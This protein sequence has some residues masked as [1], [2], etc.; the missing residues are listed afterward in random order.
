MN[1]LTVSLSAPIL[2]FP[3]CMLPLPPCR[4]R[5]SQLRHMP[6]IHPY[7]QLHSTLHGIQLELA[8]GLAECPPV[9]ALRRPH[10][11]ALCPVRA[12]HLNYLLTGRPPLLALLPPLSLLASRCLIIAVATAVRLPGRLL[13][14]L[15]Q[16]PL[17][18]GGQLRG[19]PLRH[20]HQSL[21]ECDS[22][23]GTERRHIQGGKG[24]GHWEVVR[25]A[26]G[27]GQPAGRRLR[28]RLQ[29]LPGRGQAQAAACEQDVVQPPRHARPLVGPMV[30]G[31]ACGAGGDP[32]QGHS[33][34]PGSLLCLLV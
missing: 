23:R 21:Q 30:K 16:L 8:Q 19:V 1:A 32:L 6:A 34:I 22:L 27:V 11:F 29:C 7:L 24:G 26:S 18:E 13:G 33:E 2:R 3:Q 14:S 15:C 17:L 10:P 9:L 12:L 20:L 31:G 5:S 28:V 25:G 4:S